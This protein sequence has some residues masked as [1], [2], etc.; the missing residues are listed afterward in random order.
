MTNTFLQRFPFI[1]PLATALLA[2]IIAHT[3]FFQQDPDLLAAAICADL[4]LTSPMLYFLLIRNT[5]V[6]KVTVLS[7]FILGLILASSILPAEQQW[8][9]ALIK[10]YALPVIELG[11]V[12]WIL[13][14]VYRIRKTFKE[15]GQGDFYTALQQATAAILP[16][17]LA[18]FLSGEIAAIYYSLFCWHRPNIKTGEFSYHQRSGTGLIIGTLVGI[19]VVETFA[20]HLLLERWNPVVAWVASALSLY[21]ILQ[22]VAIARSARYRPIRLCQRQGELQLRFGFFTETIVPIHSIEKIIATSRTP[23]STEETVSL[24]PLGSFSSHNLIIHLKTH[25]HLT[26]LYGAPKPFMAITLWVDDRES[27]LE[28]LET[29]A[30]IHESNITK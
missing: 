2:I 17:R 11:V 18:G 27:F 3:T 25:E 1:I 23:K 29:A 15:Q 6:P 20:V 10:T 22:L 21:G 4:L 13:H 9:P 26:S 5:S 8:L 7:V 24:S 16:K 19:I 14:K 12:A 30:D 28:A